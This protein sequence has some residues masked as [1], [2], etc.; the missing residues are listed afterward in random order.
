MN[1]T[2]FFPLS[3][4]K[5][6]MSPIEPY[7]YTSNEIKT[8][9]ISQKKFLFPI[10]LDFIPISHYTILR[11][12]FNGSKLRI[13]NETRLLFDQIS[14]HVWEN[15]SMVEIGQLHLTIQGKGMYNIKPLRKLTNYL[16][17]GKQSE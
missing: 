4:T 13:E 8:T 6:S 12:G 1:R 11:A 15:A 16:W 14:D 2:V 7:L 3:Q 17:Y 9:S 10:I 5:P